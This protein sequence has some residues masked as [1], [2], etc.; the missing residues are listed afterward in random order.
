[1]KITSILVLFALLEIAKGQLIAAAR[2]LY[3][4]I[5]LSFGAAASFFASD[6]VDTDGDNWSWKNWK[7]MDNI[8]EA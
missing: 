7:W 1:M 2:G 6:K 3:Q 8:P 4:P 5:L